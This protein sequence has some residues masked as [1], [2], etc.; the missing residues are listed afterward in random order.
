MITVREA[1]GGDIPAI[2]EIFHA[3]YGEHHTDTRYY[4]QDALT[5]LVYSDDTVILIAED[6]QSGR[7]VGTASVILEVGA[8]ADLT[9]EFGRLAVLPEARH[10]GIGNLLMNER[11]KRVEGRLQVG[12]I[13]ARAVHPYAVRIAERHRFHVIG[14]LPLKWLVQERESLVLLVRYFSH[15]LELRKNHPRIIPEVH[16][17]AT[18]AMK[19]CSLDSDAIVDDESPAYP[20]ADAFE[21]QEL[22]TEGYAPLLRIERGRVR[23]REIF[24]PMRLHYGYFMLQAKRSRYLI[25]R[26]KG[27]VAGAIGF[28][29]DAV[30]KVVRVFE[31]ISL[32]DPVVR[33]LLAEL[34]RLCREEWQICY[35]EIDVSAYSPRMQRTLIELG[36]LPVAYVPA[37]VFHEVERLDAIKMVRLLVTPDVR[38]A[39]LT[40]RARIMA[41]SVLGAFRHRSILPRIGQV[42]EAIP[43]F[44]G[45]SAEQ[46]NRVAGVCAVA[47]FHAGAVLFN[48]GDMDDQLHVILSGEV[49]IKMG[50]LPDPVGV[51]KS[52]ECVGEISLLTL[53][54]HSATATAQTQVETAVL[55]R[56]ALTELVR[57][58]P[59]IGLQIYKNLA[60]GLGDKLQRSD[61]A[62]F[63]RSK[64]TGN[65][66]GK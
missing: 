52:G 1:T 33:F 25:A 53:A 34:E 38:T 63:W 51:V 64:T 17:L 40:P 65:D 6:Q 13:E 37:L 23:N 24:G 5:K 12:V 21:M 48:E 45:L 31:L 54:P 28:T 4:D 16:S 2:T 32:H 10:L 56:Q 22:T 59:D 57:L 30:E 3:S 14:F 15:A 29:L 35:V 8:F 20:A 47:E 58:R 44:R 42:A 55:K 46:L 61:L 36:F 66:A 39:R 9:G 41:E 50:P 49:E 43:L 11:I 62:A 18:L 7:I 26:Q 27:A 19:N 60:L